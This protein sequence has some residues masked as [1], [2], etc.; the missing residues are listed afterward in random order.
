LEVIARQAADMAALAPAT[1]VH[2]AV[3]VDVIR[4]VG[5]DGGVEEA[6]DA[7]QVSGAD[8]QRRRR[9]ARLPDEVAEVKH[10]RRPHS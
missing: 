10:V 8:L 1:D 2:L 5:A 9:V 4:A 7:G 6:L 3:A